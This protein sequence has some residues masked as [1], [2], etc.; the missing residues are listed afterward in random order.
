MAGID[1]LVSRVM[2]GL[3]AVIIGFTSSVA[4]IYQVVIVLGGTPELVA[5]WILMLGLVMGSTSII[6]SYYYK[7]PILIAWSTT[8]AAL[9]IST[10]DG[11]NLNEA[12]GAFMLC[13]LLVFLSGVTGWF[14]KVM[15]RIPSEL[16]CAMLAGVLVTFGIDVFNFM[17]ELPLMIGL[18]VLVYCIGKRYFARFTMLSVLITGVLL[19]WNMGHIDTSNL[20][21][22][23]S[24]FAYIAPS[25]NFQAFISIS[26]PLYIV[27]MTSQN[28]PGI[29]VLKAHNYKAPISASLNVTGF[30]NLV[31]APF[32]T[33]SINLAAITAAI[34]MSED[35]DKNPDKRYWASIAGGVFYIIMAL[36]AATLV[37]VVASLPQALILALAGIALFGT[38]A[39]SLQQALH[40]SQYS[41]AAIITF[42]VTASDLTLWSVGSACWGIIAGV[43][44]LFI[45][46]KG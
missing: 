28:L 43:L 1:Q 3:V 12:V 8:G 29:A 6:L 27:T 20:Q 13:A 14:E 21:W 4:L 31:T 16:A 24:S 32:G 37:A 38:I 25:F 19:A 18:M 2:A 40:S 10:A 9:L 5:S 33:Y 41:E 42:L 46:R 7:V 39:S 44:T 45:I 17:N 30:I 34:C 36:C 11:Y 15:N 26:I 35:A 23:A 22:Q